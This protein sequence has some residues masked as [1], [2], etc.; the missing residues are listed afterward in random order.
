MSLQVLLIKIQNNMV[1]KHQMTLKKTIKN[2]QNKLRTLKGLEA[3]LCSSN[4][5]S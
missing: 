1:L 4:I 5:F 2:T 3:C